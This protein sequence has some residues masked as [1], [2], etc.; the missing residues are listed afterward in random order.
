MGSF[1]KILSFFVSISLIFLLSLKMVAEEECNSINAESTV[2]A[3][4]EKEISR[5]LIEEEERI[6]KD[7]E[8]YFEK[9]DQLKTALEREYAYQALFRKFSSQ[10][11]KKLLEQPEEIRQL[12]GI[13]ENTDFEAFFQERPSVEVKKVL[14]ATLD[15]IQTEVNR[16]QPSE[17]DL[18]NRVVKELP[19][20]LKLKKKVAIRTTNRGTVEGYLMKISANKI[21]V[22]QTYISKGDIEINDSAKIYDDVREQLVE[23]RLKEE[24]KKVQTN[25]TNEMEKRVREVLPE[26]LC[27]AGY[28]PEK[29]RFDC[30]SDVMD[31]AKFI[32]T[33]HERSK[34]MPE[35]INTTRKRYAAECLLK[36]DS[37]RHDT[38]KN[39]HALIEKL[40]SRYWCKVC[41]GSGKVLLDSTTAV[42]LE[43]TKT[44]GIVSEDTPQSLDGIDT[45]NGNTTTTVA[46]AQNQKRG[47]AVNE[48]ISLV[49]CNACAG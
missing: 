39:L 15:K 27:K 10:W 42:A 17:Q 43:H 30:T 37:V 47:A 49:P 23:E 36:A 16:L 24:M 1:H 35:L 41:N 20:K 25:V 40:H 4:V 13:D 46:V 18:R 11:G 29:N 14:Y 22:G 34:G 26:E 48:E 44:V 32:H 5:V 2:A 6:L 8:L 21:Q 12:L 3:P 7:Y 45:N 9:L 31:F 33:W 38:I 28:L 19:P